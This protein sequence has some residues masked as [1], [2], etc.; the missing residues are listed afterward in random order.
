M[1]LVIYESRDFDALYPLTYLR[2]TFQLRCG[3]IS[4]AGRITAL[5]PHDEV[6]YCMREV[7]ASVAAQKL[8]DPINAWPGLSGDVLFVNGGWMPDAGVE[9][10]EPGEVAACNGQ[11]VYARPTPEQLPKDGIASFDDLL[12]W[13]DSL[14]PTID[15]KAR[16]VSRPWHLVENNPDAMKEDFARVGK[17]GV[18][19]E[20]SPQAALIGSEEKLYIAPGAQVQPMSVI[21]VTHGPVYID[22]GVTVFPFSRIEGPAYIGPDSQIVGANM[23]EGCSIGPVCRVGGEVEESII[24][25]HSNKYHDGFLGHAYVCEWVNLGAMTTNS[26]L[27]NDYGTVS[28]YVRGEMEDTGSTKVGCFIG[29]HSKTSIGTYFN[30]GTVVGVMCVLVGSGGVLP[31]KNPSFAWFLNNR[32][33]KGAGFKAG[34][35]TARTVTSRRGCELTDA[36]V[37]LL[38]NV[39]DMTKQELREAIKKSS[40]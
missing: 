5:V 27:K 28:V 23:R 34:V 2:P 7:L 38:E 1:K 11:I 8:S 6:C 4:L 30:T 31:K 35:D 32:F 29:D 3:Y 14:K 13:L 33:F 12:A 10:P 37:E 19:G 15:V 21:D 39:K 36:D 24:H 26:D 25:G 22:E 9:L 18:E 40:R 20:L 17:S 16:I